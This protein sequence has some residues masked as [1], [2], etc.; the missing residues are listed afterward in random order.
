MKNKEGFYLKIC[1]IIIQ[2]A[3][4]VTADWCKFNFTVGKQDV[5]TVDNQ[6]KA[7]W[8]RAQT[9]ITEVRMTLDLPETGDTTNWL[10]FIWSVGDKHGRFSAYGD[11]VFFKR[12]NYGSR[13]ACRFVSG[14]GEMYPVVAYVELKVPD[15]QQ[16][17]RGRS[18]STNT[19]PTQD[20]TQR[21]R[22]SPPPA[23]IWAEL[24]ETE[25]S[26]YIWVWPIVS[27]WGVNTLALASGAKVFGPHEYVQLSTHEKSTNALFVPGISVAGP[28]YVFSTDGGHYYQGRALFKYSRRD[29]A[30]VLW[31]YEDGKPVWNG[32]HGPDYWKH[33]TCTV[34]GEMPGMVISLKNDD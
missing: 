4:A 7:Y 6:A 14:Y 19:S 28:N 22:R 32:D 34:P 24:D 10:D 12:G 9:N 31:N 2:I 15:G 16:C 17:A 8:F 3:G 11:V 5:A 25:A 20:V 1:F 13:F 29:A 18:N 21:Q 23:P 33:R 27:L 26:D 30:W